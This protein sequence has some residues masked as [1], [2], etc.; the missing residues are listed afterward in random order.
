MRLVFSWWWL[1]MASLFAGHVWG[2]VGEV[3]VASPVSPTSVTFLWDASPDASVTGYTLYVCDWNTNRLFGINVS[4]ALTATVDGLPVQPLKVYVV[5]Y[6]A[7]G[8]ESIPS[9]ILEMNLPKNP[10]LRV[11]AVLQ[12]D[13]GSGWTNAVTMGVYDLGEAVGS[14]LYRVQLN[15][16]PLP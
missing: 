9:N 1:L 15:A 11:E 16:K 7:A 6:N 10:T 8:T 14:G 4:T 12:V 3:T 2:G 5:A 13:Q